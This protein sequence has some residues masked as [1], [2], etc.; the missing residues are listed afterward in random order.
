M[1]QGIRLRA[2]CCDR[3]HCSNTA[4]PNY[5]T[6]DRMPT[7]TER[8]RAFIYIS[9]RLRESKSEIFGYFGNSSERVPFAILSKIKGVVSSYFSVEEI[10]T[11]LYIHKK[12][13]SNTRKGLFVL[14]KKIKISHLLLKFLCTKWHEDTHVASRA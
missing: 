1:S 4:H 9:R 13:F 7:T 6:C 5:H 10:Q 14:E 12:P 2:M 3:H 8:R 11:R